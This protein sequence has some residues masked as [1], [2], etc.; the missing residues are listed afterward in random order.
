MMVTK[1]TISVLSTP[2]GM[3]VTPRSC[4]SQFTRGPAKLS[5][6]KAAFRKPAKVMA[7]WMADRKLSGACINASSFFAFLSP[8]SACFLN[9]VS[10]REITAISDAAKKALIAVSMTRM[11]MDNNGS[12]DKG[13]TS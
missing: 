2:T 13:I 7:I 5:A 4:T 10:D 9:F 3:A 1:M 6:A 8:S 12:S 11:R